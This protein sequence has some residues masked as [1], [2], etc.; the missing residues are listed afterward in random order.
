MARFR[1]VAPRIWNDEKFRGLSIPGKLVFMYLLSSPAM[2]SLGA[3]RHTIPGMA[4]EMGI[5]L[6][7]FR[8]AFAEASGR[9]MVRHD[10]G[11]S[12]VWLPNFMK[13]NGPESANVVK[14]WGNS[15]DLLP[16]C[17]LRVQLIQHVKAISETLD[18]AFRKA[19][20]KV[21][22]MAFPKVLPTVMPIQ[23]QE[24]EQE[25]EH[26]QEPEPETPP[27]VQG[28]GEKPFI[29]PPGL[30]RRQTEQPVEELQ[31]S[32]SRRAMANA[33]GLPTLPF[34][35]EAFT[36]AWQYWLKHLREKNE[37]P[38]PTST[39]ALFATMLKAGST[40][41][42][43]AIE[44][45]IQSGW[46][47]VQFSNGNGAVSRNTKPDQASRRAQQAAAQCDDGDLDFRELNPHRQAER[48]LP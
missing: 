13:Y 2:T 14:S 35:D 46:R 19:L 3:M 12:F 37:H 17:E 18:P 36:N 5:E 48:K 25:I 26:E 24:Q 42:V 40:A 29:F 10:F 23:E 8:K 27:G 38:T 41:S 39:T 11:A 21:F 33:Q 16:E 22:D 32:I 15:L 34:T 44:H 1:K 4:D 43:I 30:K 31:P 47:S 45:A 6:E 20:P 7:V 9:G 28:V